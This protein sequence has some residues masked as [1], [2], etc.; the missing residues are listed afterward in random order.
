MF[1]RIQ[2]PKLA[3]KLLFVR[4]GHVNTH[5]KVVAS[6]M[7]S[8][9]G[10]ILCESSLGCDCST[11]A[12]FIDEQIDKKNIYVSRISNRFP[13]QFWSSVGKPSAPRCFDVLDIV[14]LGCVPV[15]KP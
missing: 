3:A 10:G 4:L 6:K 11:E 1:C 15:G 7:L 2:D 5:V 14:S 9:M 8:V 13:L 12:R